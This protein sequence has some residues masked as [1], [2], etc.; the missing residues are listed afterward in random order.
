LNLEIDRL[1]RE[2][3]ERKNELEELKRCYQ[4]TDEKTVITRAKYESLTTHEVAKG[5]SVKETVKEMKVL[6]D[7]I[8][9]MEIVCVHGPKCELLLNGFRQDLQKTNA[10][11][12]YLPDKHN[13]DVKIDREWQRHCP[14]Y[15]S[16]REVV[17]V[18][19]VAWERESFQLRAEREQLRGVGPFNFFV[20]DELTRNLVISEPR[21]ISLFTKSIW[22]L[23]LVYV[24]EVRF[25]EFVRPVLVDKERFQHVRHFAKTLFPYELPRQ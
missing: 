25:A 8:R 10:V 21:W 14:H 2:L 12:K 22:S 23:I 1:N 17:L 16:D 19:Q 13:F 9:Q 15:H 20:H 11:E 3:N 24:G 7:R 18:R 5:R 4:L 6:D